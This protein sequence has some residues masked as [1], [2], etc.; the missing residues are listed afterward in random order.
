MAVDTAAKR[1]SISD[2]HLVY[3][4]GT[5]AAADRATWSG[6]YLIEGVAV[7]TV[8][9]TSTHT[10]APAATSTPTAAGHATSTHTVTAPATSTHTI[11]DG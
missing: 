4:D 10:V 2:S 8:N 7:V 1:F 3:P 6:F 9:A 5:I 11:S